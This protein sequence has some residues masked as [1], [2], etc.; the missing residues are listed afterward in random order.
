M[1]A[2]V[3]ITGP[4][5][6]NS[7]LD[8]TYI[9]QDRFRCP[10]CGLRWHYTQDPPEKVTSGFYLPGKRHLVIDGTEH[11]KPPVNFQLNIPDTGL[12]KLEIP[13]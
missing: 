1:T 12:F 5:G 10:R 6:H 9:A 11:P 3:T 8:N 7:P 2:E 13:E 4:C